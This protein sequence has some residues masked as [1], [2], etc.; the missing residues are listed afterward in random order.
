MSEGWNGKVGDQ[1]QQ[2]DAYYYTAEY[3]TK[4]NLVVIKNGSFIL[5]N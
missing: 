5:L 3:V 2:M 4:E 1:L